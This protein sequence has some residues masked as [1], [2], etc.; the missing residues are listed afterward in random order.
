MYPKKAMVT[1]V[2]TR[3]GFQYEKAFIPT[4]Q[5]IEVINSLIAAGVRRLEATSFV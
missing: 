5:K 3:D 4:A 2:G 1:E